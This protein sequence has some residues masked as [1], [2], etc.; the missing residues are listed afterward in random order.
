MD[1]IYWLQ[2]TGQCGNETDIRI[3]I[4]DGITKKQADELSKKLDEITTEYGQRNDE[5]FSYFNYHIAIKDAAKALNIEYEYPKV[6]YTI[7]V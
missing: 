1:K 2:I 4:P 5:D 6:D 7:Y 3:H